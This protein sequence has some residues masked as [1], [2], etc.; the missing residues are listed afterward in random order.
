MCITWQSTRKKG[1]TN[2]ICIFVPLSVVWFWDGRQL[3]LDQIS[4]ECV[5]MSPFALHWLFF[6]MAPVSC[7]IVFV[8]ATAVSSQTSK[9]TV[10]FKPFFVLQ[11]CFPVT[12]AHLAVCLNQFSL[13]PRKRATEFG[14]WSWST[15]FA[16]ILTIFFSYGISKSHNLK[17]LNWN[18]TLPIY[19]V[20]WV[21]WV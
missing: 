3:F 7:F 8:L 6:Q 10:S 11:N 18:S 12:I 1:S 21:Y 16:N 5:S 19:S 14:A 20:Y 9:S 2:R 15:L 4:T 17:Y 13:E